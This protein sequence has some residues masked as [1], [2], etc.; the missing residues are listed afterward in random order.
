MW[1]A[2]NSSVRAGRGLGQVENKKIS[3][4]NLKVNWSGVLG[5]GGV[6]VTTGSSQV[7]AR[8]LSLRGTE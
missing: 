6:K 1:E 8:S 4:Q 2:L 5:C 7:P 3:Q